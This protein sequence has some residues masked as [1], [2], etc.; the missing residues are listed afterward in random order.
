MEGPGHAGE[1]RI[2]AP[3]PYDLVSFGCPFIANPDLV[4]LI[5]FWPS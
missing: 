2:R 3:G 1:P 5:G 4:E